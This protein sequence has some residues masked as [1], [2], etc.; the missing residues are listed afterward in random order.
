MNYVK[1]AQ[2]GKKYRRDIRIP[3]YTPDT[4]SCLTFE[5]KHSTVIVFAKGWFCTAVLYLHVFQ[6]NR[7]TCRVT[8][9]K[10]MFSSSFVCFSFYKTCL[11]SFPYIIL[12]CNNF[13]DLKKKLL[14]REALNRYAYQIRYDHD[15]ISR[16]QR[17]CTFVLSSSCIPS[18]AQWRDAYYAKSVAKNRK[19]NELPRW[20][21]VH[22]ARSNRT[23]FAIFNIEF[24]K[25]CCSSFV[26]HRRSGLDLEELC[27][28]ANVRARFRH[29]GE[30]GATRTA[31][32]SLL[33]HDILPNKGRW[34][35][36]TARIRGQET[37]RTWTGLQGTNWTGA[38]RFRQFAWWIS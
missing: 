33:R 10:L 29:S 28:I 11:S 6:N 21:L 16:W 3:R 9:I 5:T 32:Y 36:E 30:E 37:S 17:S 20:C 12:S 38:S 14:N 15:L 27:I 7:I 22:H 4:R 1:T 31:R 8:N 25:R 23:R 26:E 13:V 18:I 19:V 34:R 24:W 2:K 35:A